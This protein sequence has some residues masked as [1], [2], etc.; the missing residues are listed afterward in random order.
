MEMFD[1]NF[2]LVVFM[3]SYSFVASSFDSHSSASSPLFAFILRLLIHPPRQ[4]AASSP[5][6]PCSPLARTSHSPTSIPNRLGLKRGASTSGNGSVKCWMIDGRVAD[7]LSL[8]VIRLRWKLGFGDRA[9]QSLR[10]RFLF[11]LMCLILM[12]LF[13]D[14]RF[15]GFYGFWGLEVLG[16]SSGVEKL[17]LRCLVDQWLVV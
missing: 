15:Q 11:A 9:W 14:F 1:W 8:C 5:V 7:S 4:V 3:G 17:R 2:I 12:F 16:L 10:L 13:S 6:L